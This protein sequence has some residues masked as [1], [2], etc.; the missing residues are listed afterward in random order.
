MC[1]FIAS[2]CFFRTAL[3]FRK[4]VGCLI[5]NAIQSHKWYA[6]PSGTKY[7]ICFFFFF[8]AKKLIHA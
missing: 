6:T 3:S 5:T 7:Y 8:P 4:D 2:R 1:L